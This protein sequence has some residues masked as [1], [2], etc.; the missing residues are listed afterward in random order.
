MIIHGITASSP[1]RSAPPPL[2]PPV[3]G[4]DRGEQNLEQAAARI[5]P[6]SLRDASV[7]SIGMLGIAR[8]PCQSRYKLQ[9]AS[10]PHSATPL[11]RPISAHPAP[12]LVVQGLGCRLNLIF[13]SS[14]R[15]QSLMAAS[16]KGALATTRLSGSTLEG[17]L[18]FRTGGLGFRVG[19]RFHP[20]HCGS[21]AA[22]PVERV[23][24]RS[25]RAHSIHPAMMRTP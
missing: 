22:A 2:A 19:L 7:V 4:G 15:I 13:G 16:S 1:S 8:G 10:P 18:G 23:R 11:P 12:G 3:L 14:L 6:A 17:N 25:M 24:G 20:R 21:D 5:R 9:T